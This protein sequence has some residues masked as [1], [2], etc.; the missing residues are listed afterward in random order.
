MRRVSPQGFNSVVR[1][2][3]DRGTF[4]RLMIVLLC[5]LVLAGGFVRAT[6]QHVS[7]VRFGYRSEELRRER[8]QLLE[9]QRQLHLAMNEIASPAKLERAA[10]EIGLEPARAAQ[11][12]IVEANESDRVMPDAP[13]QERQSRVVNRR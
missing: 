12:K 6:A 5:G 9:Q 10:R 7:A 8:A 13:S 3:H 2:E 1:R 11:V 4:L